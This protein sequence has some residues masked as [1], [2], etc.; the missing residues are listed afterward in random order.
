V[1]KI[2]CYTD[3]YGTSYENVHFSLKISEKALTRAKKNKATA[4]KS[5]S[6]EPLLL[7]VYI[8]I[9]DSLSRMTFQR[10]LPKTYEFLTEKLKSTVFEGYNCTSCF[11]LEI[12]YLIFSA[13]TLLEMEHRAL[14]PILTGKT[15]MELPLT[16]KRYPN[17]K[18][19]NIYPFIWKEFEQM[20]MVL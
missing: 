9:L 5:S 3:E 4:L 19:V 20:G 13:T 2:Q 12:K 18:Y 11:Y 1:F 7:N 6:Q 17:A 16:R 8:I 10:K 14:I 15:E